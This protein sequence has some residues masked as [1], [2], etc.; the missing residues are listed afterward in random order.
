MTPNNTRH[1]FEKDKEKKS[2]R[3]GKQNNQKIGKENF[4]SKE[5]FPQ[6]EKYFFSPYINKN[7]NKIAFLNSFKKKNLSTLIHFF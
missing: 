1:F 4:L 7:S 2:L 3:K 6:K 5:Q